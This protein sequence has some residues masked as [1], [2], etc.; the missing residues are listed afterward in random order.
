MPEKWSNKF[1]LFVCFVCHYVLSNGF[2]PPSNPPTA[3]QGQGHARSLFHAK[4]CVK[5]KKRRCRASFSLSPCSVSSFADPIDCFHSQFPKPS[6]LKPHP[7]SF[8]PYYP[9][10]ELLFS[11]FHSSHFFL[12]SIQPFPPPPCHSICPQEH[13][14]SVT[15]K[16]GILD[17][18]RLH[19]V[20][21]GAKEGAT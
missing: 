6:S 14:Y 2:P 3:A 4:S 10:D 19:A 20:R 1:A 17:F 18:N 21:V 16:H 5:T 9:L 15:N 13:R 12:F 11:I 7:P 8:P